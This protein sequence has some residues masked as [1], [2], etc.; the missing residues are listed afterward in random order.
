MDMVPEDERQIEPAAGEKL[1]RSMSAALR[2]VLEIAGIIVLIAVAFGKVSSGLPTD[3][4]KVLSMVGGC[5]AG[6]A[7]L[8]QLGDFHD[9]YK[10]Q[11]LSEQVRNMI[12][13]ASFLLGMLIAGVGQL[14]W[15]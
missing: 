2:Q 1:L 4:G 5:I 3:P 13:K 10:G 14:W 12:F 9:S 8:F 6:W 15:V 11:T 7:T